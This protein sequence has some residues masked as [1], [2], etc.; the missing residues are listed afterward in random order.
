MQFHQLFGIRRECAGRQ[1]L[2]QK[3]VIQFHQQ[4]WAQLHWCIGLEV[5]PNFHTAHSAPDAS[6]FSINLLTQKLLIER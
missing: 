5:R 1:H 4:N 3:D 6:N 2:A